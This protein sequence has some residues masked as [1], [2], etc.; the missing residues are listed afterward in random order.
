[1]LSNRVLRTCEEEIKLDIAIVCANIYGSIHIGLA[2]IRNSIMFGLLHHRERVES[3]R[4]SS[5]KR[6][7]DRIY[8]CL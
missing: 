1:V 5:W 8:I 7:V 6:V 2:G 4:G 3:I